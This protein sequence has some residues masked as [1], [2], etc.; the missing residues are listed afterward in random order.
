VL[1]ALAA[2]V[3]PSIIAGL[4]AVE[5]PAP[6][7]SPIPGL[8]PASIAPPPVKRGRGR[9]RTKRRYTRRALPAPGA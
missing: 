7:T 3:Q 9:P 5:P 6:G 1:D 8:I 2:G 4:L